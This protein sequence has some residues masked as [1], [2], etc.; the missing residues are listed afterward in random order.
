MTGSFP[1]LA[2]S[3]DFLED[4]A[5]NLLIFIALGWPRAR[6]A[7]AGKAMAL[8]ILGSATV[9]AWTAIQRFLDPVAPG[10][11]PVVLASLGVIAINGARPALRPRNRPTGYRYDSITPPTRA[12]LGPEVGEPDRPA[13]PACPPRTH[14][15]QWPRTTATESTSVGIRARWPCAARRRANPASPGAS[16]V[17]R[18]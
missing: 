1:L 8:I 5:I 7:A 11:A 18:G 2:D 10:V 9:A 12:D 13:T 17:T 16:S 14:T 3:V 4:A 6:R 15:A